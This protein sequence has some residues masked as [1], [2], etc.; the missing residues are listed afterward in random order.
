MIPACAKL[1]VCLCCTH[2]LKL[3]FPG[4]LSCLVLLSFL[5]S[6]PTLLFSLSISLLLYP[7]LVLSI[8]YTCR[9]RQLDDT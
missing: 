9:N 8:G 5:V 2:R 1:S 3:T 4:G 6:S 7:P